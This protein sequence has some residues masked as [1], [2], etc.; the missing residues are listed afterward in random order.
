MAD[1]PPGLPMRTFRAKAFAQRRI[2]RP[3]VTF[4][5]EGYGFNS[6][7]SIRFKVNALKSGSTVN[8]WYGDSADFHRS[9]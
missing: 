3:T 5:P 9:R 6:N 4:R 2:D 7:A 8:L 1:A